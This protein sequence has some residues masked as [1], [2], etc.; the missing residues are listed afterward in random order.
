MKNLETEYKKLVSVE[1][2]DLWDRIEKNLPEKK[3]YNKKKPISFVSV[4]KYMGVAAAALFLVLLI[5][6][7]LQLRKGDTAK[8]ETVTE[9]AP[10]MFDAEMPDQTIMESADTMMDGSP[11]SAA[12]DADS[13]LGV[14]GEDAPENAVTESAT[15]E[16][17]TT[18]SDSIAEVES[19]TLEVITGEFNVTEVI[20]ENA[21]TVY[22]LRGKDVQTDNLQ[23]SDLQEIRAVM[24]DDVQLTLEAGASYSLTLTP[25][26]GEAW[27][28]CISATE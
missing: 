3:P 26:Q 7:V 16:N 4:T 12:A 28:Y 22:V 21:V 9:C 10:D 5:P 20:T 6:G 14:T 13:Q 23:I 11:D 2:P 15:T 19:E 24:A 25:V 8:S 18:E 27:E 17:A 1:M